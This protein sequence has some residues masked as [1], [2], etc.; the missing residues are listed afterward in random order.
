MKHHPIL[1]LTLALLPMPLL[2]ASSKPSPKSAPLPAA[3]LELLKPQASGVFVDPSGVSHAWTV[4]Q[5]HGLTWDGT[6]YLPVG[7]TF[8]PATW[9]DLPTDDNWAKDKAALDLL[10]KNGVHDVL[11][12]AGTLGLTHVSPAAVQRVLDYLDAH[13]FDYGLRV[14]DQPDAPLV[15]YVVKPA[16]YRNPSPPASG[17]TRFSHIPGLTSAFYLLVSRHDQGI[18]ESGTAQ[19]AG[20]DTATVSLK[21]Q[22]TDDVLL[23]YPQRVY[24]PGTPESRLPDL[25]QGYDEYRD[26]TLGFFSHVKLGPGFRFFSDPLTADIGFAGEVNNVV[27]TSDGYR[28]DFQAWL[29]KKYNHNVDDLNRGWGIKEHD[30]PDFAVASRCLPLWS[31]SKGVAAIYDPVKKV[32]Y[33]VLNENGIGGHLWADLNQFRLESVRGYMNS[34][35]DVL[36]KGVA[37]VPVLYTWGGRSGLYTNTDTHGGFD[38]LSMDSAATA[39]YAFAQAEDTPRTT[40]LIADNADADQ[41]ALNEDWDALKNLGARGFFASDAATAQEARRL[42]DYGAE[43]SFQ[44][45]DLTDRPRILPYPAGAPG[46]SI[47]A[48]RLPDGVWWLPSYRAGALYQNGDS[49]TLGPELRGY[50]LTDPD[51]LLPRFVVWSPH[52]TGL[53]D[54]HFPFPKDAPVQIT[55]AAGVPIKVEKKKDQWIVP[56]GPDPIIF[57]HLPGVPLPTEAADAADAEAT[58][59]LTMA[60]QQGLPTDLYEQQLFHVRNDIATTPQASDLR[61]NSFARL[62]DALTQILQPFVWLEGES[63]SSYTFDSLVSDPEASGGSFLSLD[64]DRPPPTSTGDSGGGYQ[65]VYDFSVNATGSYALW[66]AAGSLSAS[67]PFTYTLDDGGAN[68]SE[69]ARPEGG[70]YGGK[71]VWSQL[72]TVSLTRGRHTLTINVTGPRS[73]DNRYVLSLDAFCL[74]RVPFHP[75]GTE[76]PAI[77]LLPPPVERDKHGKPLPEKTPKDA[78]DN[79]DLAPPTPE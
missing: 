27:P 23:L 29:N 57:T 49:F 18:D 3:P 15:G 33:A 67:S 61:Y 43:I 63:A 36:K 30:L 54:T 65:A 28:L 40:W 72:G 22:V 19:I 50:K 51:G 38:G 59:L 14:A 12:S 7:A 62:I 31:G 56:V 6:P 2:A 1:L 42:G 4:G 13:H 71:F 47:T 76:K 34:M 55:D 5:A 10:A 17:P 25:W 20:G 41:P 44:A 58:R 39:T 68:S 45:R 16:V 37:D 79:D 11:L 8:V 46:L 75:N 26:R 21:T 77:A 35:A 53:T 66:V 52:S 74:S 24:P 48:R 69:D 60:K 78:P 32:S 9:T 64:T 70:L 73:S